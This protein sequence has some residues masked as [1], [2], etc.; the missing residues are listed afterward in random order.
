MGMSSNKNV[1]CHGWYDC[2]Y[3]NY[4]HCIYGSW[5]CGAST[6]IIKYAGMIMGLYFSFNYMKNKVVSLYQGTKKM[7]A[8]EM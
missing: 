8:K 2:C 5:D 3:V 4:E 6:C 7:I 1:S